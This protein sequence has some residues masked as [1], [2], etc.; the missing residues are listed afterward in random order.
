MNWLKTKLKPT[1]QTIEQIAQTT[2]ALICWETLPDG[3]RWR[4]WCKICRDEGKP[5]LMEQTCEHTKNAKPES[6]ISREAAIKTLESLIQE[7]PI[8]QPSDASQ[9]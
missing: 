2:D 3:K 4:W 5:W 6:N 9:P 7:N 8:T 1:P